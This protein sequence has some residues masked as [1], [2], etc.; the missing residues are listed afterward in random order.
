METIIFLGLSINAIESQSILD[1]EYRDPIVG[2]DLDAITWPARVIIIDG[3]LDADLRISSVEVCRA[4]NRGVDIYG[5]SSMG[6]LLASELEHAGMKGFGRVFKALK[7]LGG[8]HEALIETLYTAD[9]LKALSVPLINA[10]VYCLEHEFFLGNIHALVSVLSD[11]PL[12]ERNWIRIKDEATKIGIN[13]PDSVRLM[14][15]KRD[16]ASGLLH[17]IRG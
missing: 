5:A 14:N 10:V 15:V 6:A 1:A 7:T 13:L 16:D 12:D 4:L 8:R 9:K 2:G 17:A 3:I 11:I